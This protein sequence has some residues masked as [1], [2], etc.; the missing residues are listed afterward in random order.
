MFILS[1]SP[2]MCDVIII[3]II[4]FGFITGFFVGMQALVFVTIGNGLAIGLA[5]ALKSLILPN[6]ITTLTPLFFSFDENIRHL[7]TSNFANSLYFLIWVI[8][9][10]I[11]FWLLYLIFKLVI[12]RKYQYNHL[13]INSIG[14]AVVNTFRMGLAAGYII[15]FAGSGLFANRSEGINNYLINDI[16]Q[17]SVMYKFYSSIYPDIPFFNIKNSD[18]KPIDDFNNYS[19]IITYTI[20]GIQNS[21]STAEIIT[22]VNTFDLL[23]PLSSSEKTQFQNIINKTNNGEYTLQQGKDLIK[24]IINTHVDLDF[25]D[26]DFMQPKL[27]MMKN[28]INLY[29]ETATFFAKNFERIVEEKAPVKTASNQN[30]WDDNIK[31]AIKEFL[32]NIKDINAQITMEVAFKGNGDTIKGLYDAKLN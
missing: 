8:G 20:D 7:M 19:K 32:S 27:N 17:R 15:L 11:I 4:L 12:M 3:A 18:L 25:L 21:N 22:I 29:P 1:I 10:D 28:V 31:P 30:S 14:G 23:Q 2:F 16:S 5:Y 6:F 26:I 9:I 24:L 13:A